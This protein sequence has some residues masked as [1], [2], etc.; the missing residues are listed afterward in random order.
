MVAISTTDDKYI[1]KIKGLHQIWAL[2]DKITIPKNDIINVYQDE[3]ELK[4]WKGFRVGTYIPFLITA[5]T[6][7]WKGKRNFW[8]MAKEKNTI[9]VELKNHI[10]NKL[11]I[12]VE[13]PTEAIELLLHKN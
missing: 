5:G 13:N 12:E 10:Y 3:S 4:K 9:I 7:S 1:F 6:F 8:D 11:Y 2:Q